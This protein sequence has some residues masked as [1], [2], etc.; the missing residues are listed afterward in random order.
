[1]S[2]ITNKIK[3]VLDGYQLNRDKASLEILEALKGLIYKTTSEKHDLS[4]LYKILPE[5][6][7]VKLIDYYN[8]STLKVPSKKD[9]RDLIILI[10]SFYLKEV[11]GRDW[12]YIKNVLNVDNGFSIN[13]ITLGKR[14]AD[15][16][17]TITKDVKNLFESVDVKNF[18]DLLEKVK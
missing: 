10:V 8:G 18:V 9:Y 2:S 13:S 17:R 1:M 16:K 7:V 12:M 5:E 15:I 6:Y 4:Y 14:I 11:E 3:D